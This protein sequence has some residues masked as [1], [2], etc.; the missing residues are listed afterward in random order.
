[1]PSPIQLIE[2]SKRLQET[3]TLRT[4][5]FQKGKL[6][7]RV[8]KDSTGSFAPDTEAQ[9]RSPGG[10]Y[11]LPGSCAGPILP[12]RKQVPIATGDW[13]GW[14]GWGTLFW[15]EGGPGQQRDQS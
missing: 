8:V 7:N 5:I 10:L 15:G 3:G 14:D 9:S 1:M 6:R 11:T 13:M 2:S 4:P 12:E